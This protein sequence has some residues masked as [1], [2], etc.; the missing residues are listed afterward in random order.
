MGLLIN[1]CFTFT[2]KKLR[3]EGYTLPSSFM[4]YNLWNDLKFF[5]IEYKFFLDNKLHYKY[6]ESFCS[7]VDE[8][9]ENDIIIDDDGV[10]VAINRFK[11]ISTRELDKRVKMY[12]IEKN[13]KILRINN[14]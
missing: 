12:D 13:Q 8:A 4:N 7:Y 11:Y 6:F 1:N 10:G 9:K 2:C 3:N 14:E 5:I